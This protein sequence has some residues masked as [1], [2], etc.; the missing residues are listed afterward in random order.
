[1]LGP[2]CCVVLSFVYSFFNYLTGKEKVGCYTLI[3]FWCNVTVLVLY[4]CILWCHGLVA[5]E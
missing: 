4:V 1:M 3:A 5:S 2:F